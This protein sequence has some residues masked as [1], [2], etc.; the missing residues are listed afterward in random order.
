MSI[1]EIIVIV[2]GLSLF[3]II[4]SV[5]NA[6]INADVLATMSQ[7]WRRWFLLYG[8][9]FAVFVVRGLLPLLIVHFSTPGLS[10]GDTLTATFSGNG[11]AKEAIERQAPALLVG[12]GIFL[13]FLFLHWLFVEDK[14]YAFFIERHIH[15]RLYFWFYAAVSLVLLFVVWSTIQTEPRLT[16]GAVTGSTAFFII[17]G[18]KRNAEEKE[19]QLLH[20]HLSDISKVLYLEMIDATF[21]MD[22]VLGAFA[23]TVSVPL[24]L[25]GN[26]LGALVV[27]YLTVRGIKTVKKFAYLKNGAMYS[28]GLLGVIMILESF[29]HH[30]YS[31]MPPLI[32]LLIVGLFFY[33]SARELKAKHAKL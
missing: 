28:I 20:G 26:G 6:V 7:R 4:T 21:S 14:K 10:W 32:T 12:G 11:A 27:R 2:L 3:E 22:G 18:F 24:I 13:L 1:H 16:L 25:I 23:F 5:D 30:V 17:N 19:K 9:V 33:L 8:I 31:W 29:G 15:Q